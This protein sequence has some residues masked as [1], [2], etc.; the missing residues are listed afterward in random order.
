MWPPSLIFFLFGLDHPLP[1][2]PLFVQICCDP[3]P[4]HPTKTEE[5]EE[6]TEKKC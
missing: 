5:P 3:P 1:V 4:P 6:V 2:L